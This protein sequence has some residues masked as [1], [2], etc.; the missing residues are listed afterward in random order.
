MSAVR[1]LPRES[2]WIAV[3]LKIHDQGRI[4]EEAHE[5]KSDHELTDLCLNADRNDLQAGRGRSLHNPEEK[6][7]VQGNQR[8]LKAALLRQGVAF[9][10]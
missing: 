10:F 6:E 2:C 3:R 7:I 1:I 9:S 4:H 8:R 5:A